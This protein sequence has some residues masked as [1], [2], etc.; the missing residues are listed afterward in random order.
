MQ[1]SLAEFLTPGCPPRLQLAFE[2]AAD[3]LGC[4]EVTA[5][6]GRAAEADHAYSWTTDGQT[7]HAK[8][9]HC[10]LD[11]TLLLPPSTRA[12]RSSSLSA[13]HTG[14]VEH[15]LRCAESAASPDV[16][17]AVMRL[18]L[19]VGSA[20]ASGAW[21]LRSSQSAVLLDLC[22]QS[23]H[24]APQVAKHLSQLHPTVLEAVLS[25]ELFSLLKSWS[26]ELMATLAADPLAAKRWLGFFPADRLNAL[27]LVAR[28]AICLAL[29][30]KLGE[31]TPDVASI[32]VE[33]LSP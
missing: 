33:V 1:K 6:L 2:L 28:R 11:S 20:R 26:T 8:G 18:A 19:P 31:M 27:P 16:F 24:R 5:L 22:K 10:L 9:L 21:M 29:A 14:M 13:A 30:A 12:A 17:D 32:I 15:L 25:D 23:P 3:H 7:H 4:S